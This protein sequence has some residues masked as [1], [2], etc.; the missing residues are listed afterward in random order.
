MSLGPNRIKSFA[1]HITILHLISISMYIYHI[2]DGKRNE[3]KPIHTFSR[4]HIYSYIVILS[5]LSEA[6]RQANGWPQSGGTFFRNKLIFH[7]HVRVTHFSCL[8]NSYAQSTKGNI[9][10][11]ADPYSPLCVCMCVCI[12]AR[13][14]GANFH[15]FHK[16]RYA[17]PHF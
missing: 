7:K 6:L 2:Y 15:H 9:I 10:I 1:F 4:T 16:T 3:L 13:G 17:W 5:I 12:C 8:M 11:S 14:N